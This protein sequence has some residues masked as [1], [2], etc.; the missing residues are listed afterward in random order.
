MG[1]LI[2]VSALVLTLLITCIVLPLVHIPVPLVTGVVMGGR[3]SNAILFSLAASSLSHPPPLPACCVSSY[4]PPPSSDLPDVVAEI[5]HS[6]SP[7]AVWCDH[8][9]NLVEAGGRAVASPPQKT[10]KPINWVYHHQLGVVG[11][12]DSLLPLPHPRIH[13]SIAVEKEAELGWKASYNDVYFAWASNPDLPYAL[14]GKSASHL[15]FFFLAPSPRM[16]PEEVASGDALW[17]YVTDLRRWGTYGRVEGLVPLDVSA[18]YFSPENGRDGPKE[19][20]LNGVWDHRSD[21]MVH[22]PERDVDALGYIARSAW[23][24]QAVLESAVCFTLRQDAVIGYHVATALSEAHPLR[25]LLAPHVAPNWGSHRVLANVLTGSGG[26]LASGLGLTHEGARLAARE[27]WD[28][29]Q[30]ATFAD[31]AAHRD[32]LPVLDASRSPHRSP[33]LQWF[34]SMDAAA[35]RTHEAARVWVDA[36]YGSDDDVRSDVEIQAFVSGLR[37]DWTRGGR[38]PPAGFASLKSRSALV[39]VVSVLQWTYA[40]HKARAVATNLIA[41]NYQMGSPLA[42]TG[43]GD[44]FLDPAS[45][46]VQDL[47]PS[48]ADVAGFHMLW[49]LVGGRSGHDLHV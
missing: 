17:E 34:A 41:F 47:H 36:H 42:R 20:I 2:W 15:G 29:C 40:W 37:L 21:V 8:F 49:D 5:P 31:W 25:T 30:L 12:L 24:G 48:L 11:A 19:L 23:I 27:T 13:P 45:F 18:A 35:N 39:H 1:R 3:V 4:H 33:S 26:L 10:N 16:I 22:G 32:L 43:A 28:A 9:H 46:S 7:W 6:S 38:A 44:L 14:Q